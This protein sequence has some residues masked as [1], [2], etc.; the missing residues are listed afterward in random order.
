MALL[1]NFVPDPCCAGH[2]EFDGF[3]ARYDDPIWNSVFP[4]NGWMCGCG[5]LSLTEKEAK[6]APSF[7]KKLDDELVHRCFNWLD[8]RPDYALELV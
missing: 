2:A 4:M 5:V 1:A 8:Q 3:I 6:A 7:G